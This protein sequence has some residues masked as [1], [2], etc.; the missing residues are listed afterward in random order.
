MTRLCYREVTQTLT[1]SFSREVLAHD[2]VEFVQP[3]ANQMERE[4]RRRLLKDVK[5]AERMKAE[6]E[7]PAS[8]EELREL[9]DWEEQMRPWR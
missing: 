6:S 9:L 5:T 2:C 7:L 4:R 8:K 3:M 1:N